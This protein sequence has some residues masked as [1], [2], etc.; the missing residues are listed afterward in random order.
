MSGGQRS[1]GNGRAGAA[2]FWTLLGI[3]VVGLA[4]MIVIPLT[5]R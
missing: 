3:I 2:T 4:V 1:D 5:G